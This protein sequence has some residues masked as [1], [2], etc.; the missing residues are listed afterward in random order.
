VAAALIAYS[1]SFTGAFV[2]DDEPA[3]VENEHIRQLTP[4]SN[5]M[6]APAGTTVSGRPIAAYTLAINYALAPPDTRDTL[7]E[8]L[9]RA[10]WIDVS[11]YRSSVWGYHAFNL[12]VHI[13][14]ALTLFGVVRRTLLSEPL[15]ARY[16]P[17]AT[18]L[19]LVIALLWVV[20]PLTTASVTYVI[21][22]VESMMS[23]FYL[24]TLYGAI[25]AWDPHAS[26]GAWMSASAAACVVGMATKESMASAPLAVVLWDFLFAGRLRWRFYPV[27]AASWVVLAILVSGD[28]R[29]YAAGFGF[30]EWPWWR[31]LA[32]QAGV[33]LHY[34][35]LVV[36]PW[37]LVLDY[38]WRPASAAAAIVPVMVMATLVAATIWGIS[39]RRPL[40]FPAAVF[41]L[42]LG[43]TSSVLPIVSEV[44]AEHRMYLPLACVISLVAVTA[45]TALNRGAIPRFVR[46]VIVLAAATALCAITL[47]RNRDYAS[48]ARIW[49]DTVQKRPAN[50]RARVNYATTL[51]AEGRLADAEPHLRQAVAIDPRLAEAQ[52]ALGVALVTERRFDE[53]VPHLRQALALE[54]D[55]V[56]AHRNLGEAYAAQGAMKD[57]VRHY[58]A[59]L[60][61]RPD[62]VMLLNRIGWILATSTADELRD[63]PRA[64][65]LAERAV[66]VTQGMDA[67][68]LDT[69]A[70]AQAETGQFNQAVETIRRALDRAKTN[71][72]EM[73]PELEHR[74]SM[75][76]RHQ[77]FRQ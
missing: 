55:F 70:A 73:V 66:Q 42:V 33:I 61:L 71:R 39:R 13:A 69:L 52:L 7:R 1:N 65:A 60:R 57:A 54:P 67:E 53:G 12:L 75:Y 32:T 29:P 14:A 22:R 17:Q 21:Q 5:A 35:R 51:L 10:P 58:D 3:I 34:L 19:A 20:H 25:R 36:V 26:R 11:R 23:L 4:V 40:A 45:S 48:G 38:D 2:F 76:Q 59:A 30:A 56:E 49:F 72:N 62:D 63:G 9:S 46:P 18:N 74:R 37:P 64:R 16:E 28:H 47:D 44:A 50:A 41:F 8:P 31:Y 6:S 15:R 68:S 24:L 77:A 43:P 27:L